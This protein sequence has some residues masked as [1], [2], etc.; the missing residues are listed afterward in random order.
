MT[1][2]PE[3][4]L[5]HLS[6]LLF[7]EKKFLE[8]STVVHTPA[9]FRWREARPEKSSG[10][11]TSGTPDGFSGIERML[12]RNPAG[13]D[14][15]DGAKL[16][17]PGGRTWKEGLML[18][19][20]AIHW[21]RSRFVCHAMSRAA[22][23]PFTARTTPEAVVRPRKT[24]GCAQFSGSLRELEEKRAS[25]R[26]ACFG[27]EGRPRAARAPENPGRIDPGSEGPIPACVP[28]FPLPCK[29]IPG[30]P[31][32]PP[33]GSLPAAS[34][35]GNSAAGRAC[36]ESLTGSAFTPALCSLTSVRFRVFD[37]SPFF[38]AVEGSP[39]L[40][41]GHVDLR[42]SR[43]SQRSDCVE[44]FC[45]HS[46]KSEINACCLDMSI[47]ICWVDRPAL[48]NQVHAREGPPAL[49]CRAPGRIKSMNERDTGNC[50]HDIKEPVHR[51]GIL[52]GPLMCGFRAPP[53]TENSLRYTR[54][55]RSRNV[56]FP[57]LARVLARL[58]KLS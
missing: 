4:F 53:S 45:N 17:E 43:H 35:P 37:F 26:G 39:E 50:G 49:D 23:L 2:V 46:A 14:A 22:A 28:G 8:E 56:E 55:T 42:L 51:S 25:R 13:E 38:P 3:G 54:K 15:P 11:E 20:R 36:C 30:S 40:P 27:A 10:S 7:R 31:R 21:T 16:A 44:L 33:S 6:F 47:E 24:L 32:A 18:D 48:G 12:H 57:P 52:R 19:T 34:T 5:G 1:S 9:K 58:G 29:S 41:A